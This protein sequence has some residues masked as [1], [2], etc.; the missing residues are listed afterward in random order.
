MPEFNVSEVN[1]FVTLGNAAG[2]IGKSLGIIGG[3]KKQLNQPTHYERS[4]A[5]IAANHHATT[6]HTAQQASLAEEAAAA[7][8]ARTQEAEAAAHGRR[9]E[10]FNSAMKHVAPGSSFSVNI[11]GQQVSGVKRAGTKRSTSAPTPPTPA[12]AKKTPK[13]RARTPK[14]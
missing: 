8:H 13:F 11:D 3:L 9:Q 12:A 4:M 1:P 10:F 14:G 6:L 2:D 7:A 5:M